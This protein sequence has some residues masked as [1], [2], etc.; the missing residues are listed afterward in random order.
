MHYRES[1]ELAKEAAPQLMRAAFLHNLGH[2]THRQGD[3]RQ[4]RKLFTEALAQ[5][6]ELGD[7]R[8]VAESVAGLAC[9]AAEKEPQR[10]ARLFGSVTAVVE[11]MGSQ[12]NPTNQ[13]DY[14]HSLRIARSR[15]G[16]EAFEAGWKHGRSMTLEQAITDALVGSQEMPDTEVRATG[17][18]REFS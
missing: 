11:A 16:G 10:T 12:L 2:V 14:D 5:F 8:G 7:R 15:L 13:A 18:Q 1:L 9:L 3:E 4:A 6:R 17:F